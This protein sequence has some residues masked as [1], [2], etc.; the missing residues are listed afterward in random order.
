MHLDDIVRLGAK[1]LP[2]DIDGSPSAC[3]GQCE[4]SQLFGVSNSKVRKHSR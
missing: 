3:I 2:G 1:P 4:N